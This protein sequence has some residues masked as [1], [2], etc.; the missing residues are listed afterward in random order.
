M[1]DN[2]KVIDQLKEYWLGKLDRELSEDLIYHCTDHTREV[3]DCCE[4]R[5][6]AEGLGERQTCLLVVAALFHD[7]GF[8]VKRHGHE[9]ESRRLAAEF[10]PEYG[11]TD[12][13]IDYIGKLIITTKI[14]QSPFDLTS[15]ILCDCDLG[16]LGTD[17][18][19]EISDTLWKEIISGGNDLGLKAWLD[20]Q[21]GFLKMH[22]YHTDWA[23]ETSNSK[24]KAKLEE[25][26]QHRN[27]L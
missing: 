20:L 14:P 11:F 16:Y 3:I 24:K 18:Y 1:M 23:K 6:K 21:I 17:R 5:A 12:E 25:L 7:T 2:N 10:L 19:D 13:E 9:D 26:I 4:S 15:S 22:S 27:K 8:L